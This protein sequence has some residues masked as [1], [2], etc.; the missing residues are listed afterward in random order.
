MI[1]DMSCIM[2]LP[3]SFSPN[4]F[5]ILF[6]LLFLHPMC[7]HNKTKLQKLSNAFFNLVLIILY[8]NCPKVLHYYGL[9]QE[10][11]H[12]FSFS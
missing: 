6:S 5:L 2:S 4:C 3:T 12:S 7:L 10:V 1:E 8:W 9:S 11:T